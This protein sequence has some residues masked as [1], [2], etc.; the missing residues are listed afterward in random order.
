MGPSALIFSA[1]GGPAGDSGR[2]GMLVQE[3]VHS[4][5]NAREA[6][7]ASVEGDFTLGFAAEASDRELLSPWFA[8]RTAPAFARSDDRDWIGFKRAGPETAPAGGRT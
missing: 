4:S 7:F 1:G 2:G 8:A 3:I 5:S 6:G